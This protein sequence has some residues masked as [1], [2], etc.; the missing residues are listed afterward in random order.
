MEQTYEDWDEVRKKIK[1]D[2]E[3]AEKTEIGISIAKECQGLV[4]KHISKRIKEFPK[5]IIMEEENKEKPA[6]EVEEKKEE[7]EK[8]E[9]T[10]ETPAE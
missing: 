9:E 8:E 10:E 2:I 3:A 1:L 7:E 4:L 6:E 5:P